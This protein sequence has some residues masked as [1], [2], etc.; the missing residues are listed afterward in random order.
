MSVYSARPLSGEGHMKTLLDKSVRDGML[1]SHKLMILALA[2]FTVTLFPKFGCG[3]AWSASED[4]SLSVLVSGGD[5]VR[6]GSGWNLAP[7]AIILIPVPFAIYLGDP[8][9]ALTS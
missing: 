9:E 1:L 7:H 8:D 2:A 3:Q 6:R 5:F 4:G